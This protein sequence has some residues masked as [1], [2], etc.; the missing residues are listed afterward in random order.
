MTGKDPMAATLGL[1]L[2]IEKLPSEKGYKG[3]DESSNLSG[4]KKS[5]G[6]CSIHQLTKPCFI[7][8]RSDSKHQSRV[9]RIVRTPKCARCRNHGVVSCLKGHK[10][11][12]RW[13]DCHCTN[14]LLVVERQRVMAAQ[15]ALRR[16]QAS[17]DNKRSD[18]PTTAEKLRKESEREMEKNSDADSSQGEFLS[19]KQKSFV[20]QAKN[21]RLRDKVRNQRGTMGAKGGSSGSI[22]RDILEGHRQISSRLS[23]RATNRPVI[24]LPP[25]VSERMRKRR[26]FADK[27]LEA[28]MLQRECEWTLMLACAAGAKSVPT[29][30]TESVVFDTYQGRLPRMTTPPEERSP[31]GPLPRRT[32]PP[33][34]RSP[35]GPLPRRT[36]PPDD[37]SPDDQS[38]GRPP[39]P[40]FVKEFDLNSC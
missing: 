35:G 25:P 3:L 19:N 23:S 27:E 9:R 30:A 11:F 2:S 7:S 1:N 16:Q 8:Q 26:A 4:G 39:P 38:P 10:R 24:F 28:T 5:R 37:N 6:N 29:H 31:G 20:M 40:L 33:E 14:C 15:V 34:D 13:R 36:T 17:S 21:Y 32:A 12:C 22:A 18:G